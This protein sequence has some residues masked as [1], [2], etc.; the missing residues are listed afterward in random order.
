[1]Q[2]QI[3][4]ENQAAHLLGRIRFAQGDRAALLVIDGELSADNNQPSSVA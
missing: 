2:S 1:V 3:D 4:A